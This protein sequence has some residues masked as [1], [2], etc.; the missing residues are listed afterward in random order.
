M[1]YMTVSIVLTCGSHLYDRIISQLGKACAHMTS[2]TP[3]FLLKWLYQARKVSGYVYV[4]SG[5]RF[6]LFLR[7]FNFWFW[8]CSDWCF[9]FF[10]LSPT[11]WTNIDGMS[12]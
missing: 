1:L 12:W 2:L 11:S 5:Y 9:W 4:C 3:P 10:I 8:N 7:F 6:F